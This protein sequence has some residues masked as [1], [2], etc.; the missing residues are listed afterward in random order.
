MKGKCGGT[1]GALT[2]AMALGLGLHS[3][4]AQAQPIA[5]ATDVSGRVTVQSTAQALSI[6]AEIESG[7]R[8][9]LE[10]EARLIVLYLKSGD[11]YSFAG[12]AEVQ[13]HSAMPGVVSGAQP[14]KRVSSFA[15][16]MAIKPG[17]VTQ[18]AYV[19]RSARTAPR[20]RLLSLSGTRTLDTHPEF[21]W[22]Q[23]DGVKSYRFELLDGTGRLVIERQLNGP[24]YRLPANVSLA[25]DVTYTWEIAARLP[26]GRRYVNAGDFSLAPAALRQQ[27]ESVR[28]AAD[29][30]FS[31]RVGFATWLQQSGFKDEARKYWRALAAERPQDATLKSLAGER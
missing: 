13:F 4:S 28:P 22:Q 12:P 29:A 5:L 24:P 26:D 25:A 18:A 14:Q 10:P 17:G 31:D 27:V 21:R 23:L 2:L 6:L 11:E 16:R 3:L 8:V 20:I 30:H 19:M 9:R 15:R 7:M 1:L